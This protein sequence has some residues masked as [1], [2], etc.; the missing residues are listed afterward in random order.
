MYACAYNLTWDLLRVH[1]KW[2]EDPLLQGVVNDELWLCTIDAQMKD[3]VS[4]L[5]GELSVQEPTYSDCY[6]PELFSE[7]ILKISYVCKKEFNPKQGL[8]NS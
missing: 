5:N 6:Y 3:N 8:R 1:D 2:K 4:T 7:N